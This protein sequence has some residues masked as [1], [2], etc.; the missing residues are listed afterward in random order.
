MVKNDAV[1]CITKIDKKHF[2]V[3]TNPEFPVQRHAATKISGAKILLLS[4]RAPRAARLEPVTCTSFKIKNG[5][6]S[7]VKMCEDCFL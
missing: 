3:S 4:A 7:N 5:T 6:F 1:I 2:Y